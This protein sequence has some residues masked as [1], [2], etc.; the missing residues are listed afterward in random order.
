MQEAELTVLLELLAVRV[1]EAGPLLYGALQSAGGALGFAGSCLPRWAPLMQSA[2]AAME[3]AEKAHSEAVKH[4]VIF[5]SSHALCP[6]IK[7]VCTEGGA[8]H[9]WQGCQKHLCNFCCS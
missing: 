2:S 6:N 8:V 7:A 1:S 4:Q 5:V 9:D 3:A